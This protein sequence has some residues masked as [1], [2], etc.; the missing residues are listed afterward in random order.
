MLHKLLLSAMLGS[1]LL[2]GCSPANPADR[3]PSSYQGLLTALEE[4]GVA[5]EPGGTIDQE[6]F[7]VTGQVIEVDGESVQVFEYSDEA[8]RKADSDLI[9]E[10]GSSV[11][12]TMI[13]WIDTPHFWA[14]GRLIVLYVGS[15]AEIVNALN[16]ALGEPIA[17]GG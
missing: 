9:G 12:T 7:T 10:D 16:R 6:F 17:E 3:G 14:Q 1:V 8:A 4:D 15:N 2:W 5:A 13:T 11:G